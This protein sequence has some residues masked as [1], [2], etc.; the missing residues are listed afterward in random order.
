MRFL[1]NKLG[2]QTVLLDLRL[3]RIKS[4]IH[5]DGTVVQLRHLLPGSWVVCVLIMTDMT[6]CISLTLTDYF[7]PFNY[8]SAKT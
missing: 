1:C 3:R 4:K 5:E 8:Q 7:D 2:L 6:P